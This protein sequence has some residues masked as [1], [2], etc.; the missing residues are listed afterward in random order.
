MARDK[1]RKADAAP[2][3]PPSSGGRQRTAMWNNTKESEA[4]QCSN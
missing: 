1:L 3:T 4:T 2:G